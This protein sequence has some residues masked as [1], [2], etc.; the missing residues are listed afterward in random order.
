MGYPDI[1]ESLIRRGALPGHPNPATA[2]DAQR[3]RTTVS[4]VHRL[5]DVPALAEIQGTSVIDLVAALALARPDHMH[6]AAI[7]QDSDIGVARMTT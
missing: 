7:H 1:R 5:D 3:G 6:V 4:I 2:I